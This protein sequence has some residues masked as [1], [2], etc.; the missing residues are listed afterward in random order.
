MP[1]ELAPQCKE[2]FKVGKVVGCVEWD[3]AMEAETW[4]II[5][6]EEG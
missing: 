4:Q 1:H 3:I 6:S 5:E 2:Q